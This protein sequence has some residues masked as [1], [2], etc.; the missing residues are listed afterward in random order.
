MHIPL[1]KSTRPLNKNETT[2]SSGGAVAGPRAHLSC[3][4]A[5]AR[6]TAAARAVSALKQSAH[7]RTQILATHIGTRAIGFGLFDARNARVDLDPDCA[8]SAGRPAAEKTRL[9]FCARCRMRASRSVA[10]LAR[11]L[12][13]AVSKLVSA[14]AHKSNLSARRHRAVTWLVDPLDDDEMATTAHSAHVDKR[15]LA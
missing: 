3:S 10:L 11:S 15:A 12:P 5:R 1:G 9:F 13:A 2:T 14:S 8:G 4:R 7:T 6:A